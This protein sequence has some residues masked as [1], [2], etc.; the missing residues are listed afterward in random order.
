VEA[1]DAL[2]GVVVMLV[3]LDVELTEEED[4]YLEDCIAARRKGLPMPHSTTLS[5]DTEIF[6]RVAAARNGSRWKGRAMK[7]RP[8]RSPG[9]PRGVIHMRMYTRR[10]WMG[11]LQFTWVIM[12]TMVAFRILA[13]PH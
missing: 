9:G 1:V 4:A 13:H 8:T 10:I 12:L 6:I 7:V 5:W 2:K 3:H 11:I